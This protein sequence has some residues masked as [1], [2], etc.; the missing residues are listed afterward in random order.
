MKIKRNNRSEAGSKKK[1]GQRKK[2]KRKKPQHV[3][4]PWRTTS[5]QLGER[6]LERIEKSNT[7][8]ST[9]AI[10][11]K[12]TKQHTKGREKSGKGSRSQRGVVRGDVISVSNL[13]SIQ[14]GV[15]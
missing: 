3:T 4:V 15:Y 11:G 1:G 14:T 5:S 2:L 12:K 13:K 10:K 7:R 6:R 9:T 8:T